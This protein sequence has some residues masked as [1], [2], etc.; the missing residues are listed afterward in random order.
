MTSAYL[1][2]SIVPRTRS[3]A[4]TLAPLIV[5]ALH[6]SSSEI[7]VPSFAAARRATFISWRR[8]LL[9]LGLQSQ[10]RPKVTPA[11]VR[12]EIFSVFHREGNC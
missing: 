5:T 9:P 1:S 11:E 4:A 8:F 2:F 6:K 7:G 12:F 10:P 3:Q